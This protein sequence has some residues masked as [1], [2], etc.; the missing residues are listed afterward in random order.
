MPPSQTAVVPAP[1][2][3]SPG[4]VSPGEVKDSGDAPVQVFEKAVA[5]IKNAKGDAAATS[6][7]D[8]LQFYALYKQATGKPVVHTY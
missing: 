1:G 3:V 5:H 2:A 6:T 7:D 4:A 8:K